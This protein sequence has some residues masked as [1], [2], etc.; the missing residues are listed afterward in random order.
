VDNP[1]LIQGPL[2]IFSNIQPEHIE[3]AIKHIIS[4]NRAELHDLLSQEGPF[5]WANLIAPLENMADRL[6]KAWSPV[7][8]LHS[9][10]ETDA[11]RAAYNACLP[12]LT[13]YQTDLMQDEKL[14]K[15]VKSIADG[16]EYATFNLAQRKVIEDDLRDFHL[17]GVDLSPTAKARFAELQKELTR[18]TTQF[19]ENVLDATHAWT[20][21]VTD[22]HALAGLPESVLKIAEQNAQQSGETGWK[23]TLD[24]PC[25]VAVMKYLSNRELRWLMHEAYVT[26]ASDQGPHAGRWDNTSVMEEILKARHELAN[27]LGFENYAL[28]S[29]A[30]KMAK[31]PEQVLN[32]LNDLV[33]RSAVYG[34]KEI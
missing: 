9:V 11:L 12:L 22:I 15:A 13:E 28:Y 24:Y 33:K 27:L 5:T 2:P 16:P 1:L 14:Y 29:L 17:A 21:H 26:R 10:M 4:Q 32:F 23:L 7:S 25:Y 6:S 19:S 3:P 20:L 30:T 31:K 8:H 34:V 18:L